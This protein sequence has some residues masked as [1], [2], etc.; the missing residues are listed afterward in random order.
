MYWKLLLFSI[1]CIIFGLYPYTILSNQNLFLGLL[2]VFYFVSQVVFAAMNFHTMKRIQ[3]SSQET[4]SVALLVIGYRENPDYWRD[5]LLSILA[6]DYPAITSVCAFID[7]NDEEDRYME[8]IF[9]Q[10]MT[11]HLEENRFKTKVQLCDHG[12]KRHA[13]SEGFNYIRKTHPDNEYIIVIDSDTILE[14]DSVRHLVQCIHADPRNGCA[15]GNIQ[16]FNLRTWLARIIN[17][18]YAYAFTIERSAM[19]AMGV[20]NCCSGPFSAYRQSLLDDRFIDDFLNQK[21]MGSQ[22][23]PG[24]DRHAT[25]L[26]LMR[27]HLARQTPLAI[28]KTETP[29]TLHRYFQ[30]Q[31][32]WMRSFYREQLWQIRAI[33][34]QNIYLAMITLYELFFPFMILFSFIPTFHLLDTG[35]DLGIFYHRL[36]MAI[37][38]VLL[39]TMFLMYFNKLRSSNLWNMAVFPMYF[40]FLL[41]IKMYALLTCGVQSW[42]TSSRKTILSNINP[43]VVMI[44]VSM[45]AW[46]GLLAYCGA[47]LFLNLPSI[48]VSMPSLW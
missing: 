39:R 12:G 32:R 33:P 7:G 36:L 9:N 25:L 37:G 43:D 23:G 2:I 10:M 20:M 48:H 44:Y 41:P 11:D 24:D 22:V 30:Q 45:L 47:H 19:S 40:I 38:V 1:G 34:H 4:P 31:L 29:E 18:R 3:K 28:V 5:C 27:G 16:I 14:K 13:M 46:N 6:V 26:M 15:T 21:F 8:T 17:A 35:I 42:I